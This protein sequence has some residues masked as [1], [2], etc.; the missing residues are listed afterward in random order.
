MIVARAPRAYPGRMLRAGIALLWALIVGGAGFGAAVLTA[1]L[2]GVEFDP[3]PALF[4]IGPVGSV[5]GFI[6]AERAMKACGG[7]NS[8]SQGWM[9]VVTLLYGLL[10][11]GVLQFGA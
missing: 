1:A 3:T 4:F 5:V 11:L 10:V 2:R 6:A 7:I 9:L 8:R